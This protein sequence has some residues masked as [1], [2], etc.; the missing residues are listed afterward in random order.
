MPGGV[1]LIDIGARGLHQAQP[2]A[3][4]GR[5]SACLVLAGVIGLSLGCASGM[6]TS[7]GRARVT[8]GSLRLPVPT[9]PASIGTRVLM[10]VD[11]SRIDPFDPRHRHRRLMIQI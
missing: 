10:L 2:L 4:A 8:P 11:T 7:G 9:G 1:S 5:R 3:L 6:T